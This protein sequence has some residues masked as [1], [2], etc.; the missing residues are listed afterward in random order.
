[1]SQGLT[2]PQ[3]WSITDNSN[4]NAGSAAFEQLAKAAIISCPP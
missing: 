2:W 3:L 1:M 4:P